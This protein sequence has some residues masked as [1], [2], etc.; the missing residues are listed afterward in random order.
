MLS[1]DLNYISG[2]NREF[3]NDLGLALLRIGPAALMLTHGYPKLLKLLAGGEIKFYD[4]AGL[5]PEVSLALAVF[6]EFVA[7]LALIAGFKTR[8]FAV[9]AAFTMLVAAFGA[10]WA[11]ALGDKEHSLLFAIPFLATMLLGSGGYSV[12]AWMLR[13]RASN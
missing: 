2:M 1:S 5:G 12:D 3:F 13:R 6:G 8:W 11:D 9:P 10:H 7:P 4:F